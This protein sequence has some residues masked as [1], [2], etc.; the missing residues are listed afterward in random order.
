MSVVFSAVVFRLVTTRFYAILCYEEERIFTAVHT[1][2][3]S[4]RSIDSA[5][6]HDGIDTTV[7]PIKRFVSSNIVPSVRRVIFRRIIVCSYGNRARQ[8]SKSRVSTK[9]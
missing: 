8:V 1:P 2:K 5:S 6:R 7:V 4:V 3:S 9:P